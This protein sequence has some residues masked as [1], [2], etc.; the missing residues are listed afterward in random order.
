MD[1]TSAAQLGFHGLRSCGLC[2]PDCHR[3]AIRT[4]GRGNEEA[5]RKRRAD[6]EIAAPRAAAAALGQDIRA[7]PESPSMSQHVNS[8]ASAAK[9]AHADVPQQEAPPSG[10]P[11]CGATSIAPSSHVE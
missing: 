5:R 3:E 8:V 1:G 4:A 9:K 7:D 2:R 6:D 11:Y 10:R